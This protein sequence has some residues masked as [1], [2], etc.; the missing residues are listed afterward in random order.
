MSA[1]RRATVSPSIAPFPRR[2]KKGTK[3]I[4]RGITIRNI[5]V[6]STRNEHQENENLHA[7]FVAISSCPWRFCLLGLGEKYVVLVR[8]TLLEGTRRAGVNR[9]VCDT[10]AQSAN[11]PT[12]PD[13]WAA[14][15]NLISPT[16]RA[17]GVYFP[18]NG[19][20]YAWAGASRTESAT[21]SLIRLNMIQSAI[22]G[23]PSRP[24]SRQPSEQYGLWRAN[25]RR[26]A[27]HLLRGRLGRRSDAGYRSRL[28]L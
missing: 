22:V 2:P 6:L 28:P 10:K 20:F 14:G 4:R 8:T 13:G 19:K 17:A 26:N 9:A 15:P 25:R 23:L 1:L 3:C 27:L 24:P 11:E 7:I 21:I 12:V 5:L 16:V 18:A